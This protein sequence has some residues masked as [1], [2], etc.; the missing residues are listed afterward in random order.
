MDSEELIKRYRAI[1]L[2]DEE[3]G[4]LTFRSKM[5]TQGEKIVAGCLIGKVI[6]TRGVSIEG[7]KTVM[8]RVWKTSREVKIESLGENVFMFKFGSEMDKRSILVGGPWHFDRALIVL[9][10]PAGIGDVKKQDFS[11]ASFWVQI[12]DVP[13]MCMHK[14]MADELGA[15]IGK[16]EEIETD[17]AGECFGEFLRLRISVDI[18]KPL[19]KIIELEQEGD[20]EDDIPMR[21]MYERLS[22]FCFCCGRIGHQYRECTHYKSQSKDNMAYGPWLKATSIAERLKQNRRRDRWESEARK[23]HTS[24]ST[25]MKDPRRSSTENERCRV[26]EMGNTEEENRIHQDSGMD[27]SEGE[28]GEIQKGSQKQLMQGLAGRKELED[29]CTG[30]KNLAVNDTVHWDETMEAKSKGGKGKFLSKKPDTAVVGGLK[31]AGIIERE[32]EDLRKTSAEMDFQKTNGLQLIIELEVKDMENG[33]RGGK[34]KIRKKK[35]KYQARNKEE[36]KGF[37][38]GST[39][40]KRPSSTIDWESPKPKKSKQNSP[41]NIYLSPRIQKLAGAATKLNFEKDKENGWEEAQN[42]T[43]ETSA[44]AG[45]QHRRQL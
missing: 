41:G 19:K 22:D 8:Q 5:K 38:E 16:V 18:T 10:E 13:I 44:V 24:S 30:N 42:V 11:H 33:P 15:V 2:S 12:H 45:S 3:E 20:D 43:N 39:R 26:G 35:W 36:K 27:S 9:K 4:R 6:H 28:M 29:S 25:P 21:V 17:A 40:G 37:S 23:G 14:E 34:T 32:E 7:L 1:K 31:N